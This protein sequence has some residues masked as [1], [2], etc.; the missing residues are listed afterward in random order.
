MTSSSWRMPAGCR[1]YKNRFAQG[2]PLVDAGQDRKFHFVTREKRDSVARRKL[3]LLVD[4]S[5]REVAFSRSRRISILPR[6]SNH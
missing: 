6:A 1:R 5:P 4:V 3:I 2:K